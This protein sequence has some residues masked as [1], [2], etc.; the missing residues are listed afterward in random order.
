[1]VSRMVN[2]QRLIRWGSDWAKIPHAVRG[3][4]GRD[5]DSEDSEEAERDG[6]MQ[7][8][9]DNKQNGRAR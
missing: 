2:M 3:R 7:K 5:S 4:L 1:M 6:A 9:N 8:N